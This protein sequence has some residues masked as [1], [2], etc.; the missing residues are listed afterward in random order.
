VIDVVEIGCEGHALGG[1]VQAG[2]ADGC[3]LHAGGASAR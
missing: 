1:E 2:R 3:G